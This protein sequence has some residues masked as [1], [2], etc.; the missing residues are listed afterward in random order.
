MKALK[1]EIYVLCRNR[2]LLARM[3]SWSF[4]GLAALVMLCGCGSEK[5]GDDEIGIERSIHA[6]TVKVEKSQLPDLHY[7]P[8]RVKSKVSITLSAKM[9]GYVRD[10]PHEIGDFVSK[11]ALLVGLDDTDIRAGIAALEQSFKAASRQRQAL[12]AR[13]RYVETTW[14]RI[15]KLHEEGSAT[16][17]E[18]DRITSEKSALAG[19]VSALDAQVR[20][21]RARL[22][23]ARNQLQYVIIRAP[24]DGRLTRKMVDRGA[25]VMPGMPLVQ[26]ESSGAGAWFAADVDDSLISKVKTGMPVTIYL[27]SVRQMVEAGITQVAPDSSPASHTFSILCDISSSGLPS[28]LYGRVSIPAGHSPKLLAPCRALVNRGG[29]VGVYVADSKRQVH[30]RVIK[31]GN[32]W[33]KTPSGYGAAPWDCNVSSGDCFIEVFT[34]LVPGEEVVVS[35]LNRVRE[36]FRL[37]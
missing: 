9:P 22:E 25:F 5:Q 29:I 37:E 17:D 32:K 14:N 19:Q 15:R 34:G 3:A 26:F 11:D 20:Q 23:E 31:T 36:G 18:F 12:G 13:L 27:P 4:M 30:W 21:V 35:N 33:V 16:Q 6:D 7:F 1:N 28:G 2:G 8:G 10:I 24:S